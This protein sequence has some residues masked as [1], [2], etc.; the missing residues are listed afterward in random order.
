[1]PGILFP[2]GIDWFSGLFEVFMEGDNGQNEV[3][4]KH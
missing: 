2:K 4:V 3:A 1:M